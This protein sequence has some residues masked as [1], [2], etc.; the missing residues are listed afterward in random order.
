M[1]IRVRQGKIR[2][3]PRQRKKMK[4][5][6]QGK[7]ISNGLKK[8]AIWLH[9]EACQGGKNIQVLAGSLVLNVSQRASI[10]QSNQIDFQTKMPECCNH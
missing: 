2:E 7:K 10:L 6:W 9:I 4:N 5:K 1:L 3:E 8:A